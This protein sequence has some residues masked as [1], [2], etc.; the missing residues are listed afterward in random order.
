MSRKASWIA[1]AVSDA[2]EN[3]CRMKMKI[4]K[5]EAGDWEGLEKTIND[6]LNTGGGRIVRIKYVTHA[7]HE[8]TMFVTVW[9]E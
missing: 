4:F 7:N 9:W 5:T 8:A 6:W 1:V 2:R 3:H